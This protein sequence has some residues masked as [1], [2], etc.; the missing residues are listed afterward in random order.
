VKPSKEVRKPFEF[1]ITPDEQES[2]NRYHRYLEL[3]DAAL[4]DEEPKQKPVVKTG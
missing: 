3:A 1:D 2:W 4:A